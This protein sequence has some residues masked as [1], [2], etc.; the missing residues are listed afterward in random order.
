LEA[1]RAESPRPE[2]RLELR[3]GYNTAN[4]KT[5]EQMNL[6]KKDI[7]VYNH[8]ILDIYKKDLIRFQR[9]DLSAKP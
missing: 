5:Y 1:C 6:K 3:N 2:V 4:E 8:L 7:K 9:D